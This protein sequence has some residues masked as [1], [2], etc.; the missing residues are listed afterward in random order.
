MTQL[1][2]GSFDKD[3]LHFRQRLNR[4]YINKERNPKDGKIY[5]SHDSCSVMSYHCE[6][7]LEAWQSILSPDAGAYPIK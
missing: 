2:E 6:Q 1:L 3:L 7:S 4:I 5:S